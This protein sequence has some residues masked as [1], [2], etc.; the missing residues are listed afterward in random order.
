MLDLTHHGRLPIP[1]TQKLAAV[2]DGGFIY[3]STDS[4]VNWVEQTAT[5]SRSWGSIAS[6]ADGM[7]RV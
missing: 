7:V 1:S 3:T 4:G 6:S 2:V 5:G